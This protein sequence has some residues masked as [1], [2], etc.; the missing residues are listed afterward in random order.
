MIRRR[1]VGAAVLVGATFA[2]APVAW[3]DGG[4]YLDLDRTH[5]LPGQTAQVEGYVSI[6][7]AKQDL[8]ERG[9]FYVFVVPPRTAVTEG[10]PIPADAV[11][12]GTV[13]IER[14]RGRTFELRGSFVVPELAGRSYGL[15]VCNDPCT[16]SGFREPLTGTIS[17]VATAREGE[18]LTEVSRLNGR[19]WSL[20][21]QV[22]K[23]ERANRELQTQ[24]VTAVAERSQMATAI[25]DLESEAAPGPAP[26]AERPLLPG[27][28]AVFLGVGLL[29]LALA[30]VVRRRRR[31]EL[32]APDP[33]ASP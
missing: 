4:A 26:T 25:R 32:G 21:R 10:R 16:I 1:W 7:R 12:A 9:P 17:I 27:W 24:L 22:R 5:Y 18:L 23:A 2:G 14:E 33:I 19:N 28:S 6:P 15:S 11:R 8:V 30:L 3:A 31:L 20:R 13:S 29:G